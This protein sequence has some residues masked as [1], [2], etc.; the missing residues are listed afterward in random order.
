MVTFVHA[1]GKKTRDFATDDDGKPYESMNEIV[2]PSLAISQS[3]M[4][5]D[6]FLTVFYRLGHYTSSGN[7]EIRGSLNIASIRHV[8]RKYRSH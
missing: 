3:S 6:R 2:P 5:S 7:E 8:F 4:P 1:D